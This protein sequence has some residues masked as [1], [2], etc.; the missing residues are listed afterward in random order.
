METDLPAERTQRLVTSPIPFSRLRTK[1]LCQQTG[2]ET[3]YVFMNSALFSKLIHSLIKM[4]STKKGMFW[5]IH[6]LQS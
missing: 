3:I 6:C 2:K 1:A 5:S 4:N